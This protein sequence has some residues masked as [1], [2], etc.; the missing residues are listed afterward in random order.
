MLGNGVE[1]FLDSVW[2]SRIFLCPLCSTFGIPTV[3][4]AVPLTWYEANWQNTFA[5]SVLRRTFV[6]P[7]PDL[8]YTFAGPFAVS[9]QFSGKWSCYTRRT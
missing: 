3:F 7:S 9:Q 6:E 4:Y 1:I 2:R 8:C 5:G